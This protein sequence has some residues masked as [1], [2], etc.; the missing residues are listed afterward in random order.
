MTA[1]G[2]H[3]VLMDDVPM[4]PMNLINCDFNN[5]L[6]IPVRRHK[7]EFDASIARDQHVPIAAMLQR[8]KAN[9]PAVDIMHTYDVPCSATTCTLDFDGLP[10]YRFDDYHHLSA[11]G[12]SL[13]FP[14]YMARHPAELRTILRWRTAP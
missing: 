8:L 12:S 2:K 5:D 6:L 7:C 9:N 3:V 1:A 14:K 10:I 4:I 11:A 13:L